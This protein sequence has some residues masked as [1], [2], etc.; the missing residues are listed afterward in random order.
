MTRRRSGPRSGPPGAIVFST[1]GAALRVRISGEVD[2]WLR[3]RLHE[4]LSAVRNH[5]GPVELDLGAVTFFGAE[6]VR[7]LLALEHARP[8]GS[9]TIVATSQAVERTLRVCGI[10]DEVLPRHHGPA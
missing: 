4:A 10:T 6:G 3:D 2:L 1:R 8:S 9:V 7:M 5:P